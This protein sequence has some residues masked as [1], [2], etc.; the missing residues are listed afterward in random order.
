MP[1]FCDPLLDIDGEPMWELNN[2]SLAGTLKVVGDTFQADKHKPWLAKSLLTGCPT[3][4]HRTWRKNTIPANRYSRQEVNSLKNAH[5]L[6]QPKGTGA[7]EHK[8]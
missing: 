6:Q 7:Q 5:C 1:G 3:A 4:V 8:K 2:K